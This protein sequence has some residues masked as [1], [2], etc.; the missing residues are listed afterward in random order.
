M[1]P[2]RQS[3]RSI[4]RDRRFGGFV[5]I[6]L[7]LG[8]A[9]NVTI[10][11]L[12]RSILWS[13]LPAQNPDDVVA[14]REHARG[15]PPNTGLS[16]YESW[17]AM[18]DAIGSFQ[19]IGAYS[20]EFVT[21]ATGGVAE[22]H[23]AIHASAELFSILGVRPLAGRTFTRADERSDVGQVVILSDALWREHFGGD[24]RIIGRAVQ[25]DERP[26][27]VIGVMPPGFRFPYANDV[28]LPMNPPTTLSG[29]Q[30]RRLLVL[31]RVRSGVTKAQAESELQARYVQPR[32][33]SDRPAASWQVSLISLRDQV[34]GT[35]APRVLFTMFGVAGILF[36]IACGNVA[37]LL[38][39]RGVS[40]E[41]EIATRTAIGARRVDVLAWLV[42]ESAVLGA[43]GWAVGLG[44]AYWA[45]S[46]LSTLMSPL[47]PAWVRIS[48]S[49]RAVAF[50]AALAIVVTL[51]CG[52]I[53]AW[54]VSNANLAAVL[55]HGGRQS[56]A[57]R[58]GSR[59]R[60]VLVSGQIALTTLLLICASLL[61][62]TIFRAEHSDIGF[63]DAHIVVGELATPRV[64]DAGLASS[65]RELAQTFDTAAATVPSVVASAIATT[66]PLLDDPRAIRVA[67][68]GAGGSGAPIAVATTGVTAGYFQ[69]LGMAAAS[70]RTFTERESIDSSGVA[71]VNNLLAKRLWPTSPPVGQL[72]R[73]GADRAGAV[74][75]VIGVVPSVRDALATDSLRSMLYLPYPYETPTRI[76]LLVRSAGPSDAAL[77]AVRERLRAVAPHFPIVSLATLP[78]AQAAMYKQQALLA[79]LFALCGVAALILSASGLYGVVA[80]SIEARQREFG[81]RIALGAT[82]ADVRWR[83]VRSGTALCLIGAIGGLCLATVTVGVMRALFYGVVASPAASFV[84]VPALLIIVAVVASYVPATRMVRT[85]MIHSLW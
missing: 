45:T 67:A 5:V 48:V 40:R 18:R 27:T 84:E 8:I 83:A 78:A 62:R 50:S 31:A 58:R 21:L 22:L 17:L 37:A 35:A 71:I 29:R 79:W 53:P 44:F 63:D 32:P 77:S 59:L 56:S 75:R 26:Y 24:P 11:A 3:F 41:V 4:G 7:S 76:N 2:L 25:I 23:E 60:S 34:F 74:V 55:R 52:A 20:G 51:V 15:Q 47:L 38:L 61:V 42:S 33:G 85:D 43:A 1:N 28:W 69:V 30:A 16:S 57:E 9:I 80:L 36:I 39:A 65:P 12:L 46:G 6:C 70:G 81:I 54:L 19:A 73:L 68:E 14:I 13:S 49:G 10:F 72:I 66:V 82:P 64:A